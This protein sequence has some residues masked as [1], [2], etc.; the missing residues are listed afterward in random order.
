ME[1]YNDVNIF[2][3]PTLK[4]MT[5]PK[6]RAR[7]VS[8]ESVYPVVNTQRV[9]EREKRSKRFKLTQ[10]PPPLRQCDRRKLTYGI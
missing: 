1:P 9:R 7:T 10:Q 4:F 3:G 8:T 6:I 5:R 2:A